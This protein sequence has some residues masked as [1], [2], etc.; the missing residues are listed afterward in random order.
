MK[1]TLRRGLVVTAVAALGAGLLGTPAAQADTSRTPQA[2]NA[3]DWLSGQLEDGRFV[4]RAFD[5][6]FVDWGLTIDALLSLHDIGG[7][8]ATVAD[9]ADALEDNVDEYVGTGAES[10][11]GS[12]AK[13]LVAAQA[14]GRDPRAF[15]VPT[16]TDLVSDLEELTDDETGRI[17]DQS[18]YGDYTNVFGQAFAAQGLSA[19]DSPEAARATDLLL[20]QQC[21][22]GGF[23]LELPA[24][25]DEDL[26]CTDDAQAQ[27][28]AT[29]IVVR[30]LAAQADEP[31]VDAA[32]GRARTYLAGLQAEDGGFGGGPSTEGTNTNSTASAG[33]ALETLGDDQ[34]AARAAAWLVERQVTAYSACG[35]E[36]DGERG[37]VA[38]DDAALSAGED[39]GITVDNADQWRRAT[40]PAVAALASYVDPE[41]LP[42]ASFDVTVPA[43]LVATGTTATVTATGLAPG[44]RY[45]VYSVEGAVARAGR[46]DA[47]GK[48][49]ITVTVP[50]TTGRLPV[51]VY[52]ER[53]ARQGTS[54]TPLRVVDAVKKL[55]VSVTKARV[56][57]SG[58]NRVN[59]TGLANGEK[60]TVTY[61]SKVVLTGRA[62]T[63]GTFTGTFGVGTVTGRKTVYVKGITATRQGTTTLTVVR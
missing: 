60:V 40:A 54:T 39:T 5:D 56:E 27:T 43:D 28:D 41:P 46:A 33:V 58:R 23:R 47:E 7:Y 29:A 63:S 9:V 62:T 61:R 4:N 57:R 49:V 12:T 22:G 13:L 30:A 44:E 2:V 24:A 20:Q 42:R 45:C 1:K 35:T 21:P 3:A 48:A 59:V 37:A 52:G 36:L 31:A 50:R 26:G 38:Y 18:E 32:F 34:G 10:Y 16:P 53:D 8:R 25:T 55:G 15:G 6:P 19:A 14:A 17:A 11:A 51:Y